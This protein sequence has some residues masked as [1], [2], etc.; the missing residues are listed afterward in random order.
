MTAAPSI[1]CIHGV[2]HGDADRA[3]R[4][5]WRRAI[6]AGIERSNAQPAP[7]IDF[8]DYDDLFDHA[9]LDPIVYAQALEHLLESG[10]EHGLLGAREFAGLPDEIRWTAGMIAQWASEDALRAELRERLQSKMRDKPYDAVCAFSLGSLLS[11]DTFSRLPRAIAGKDY[12]TLGSQ[13][14]D[15]YVRDFFP[16]S[17]AVPEGARTWYHLYNPRDRV[18]TSPLRIQ[19]RNFM[20]V[21]TEF[22][23]PDDL[24]NHDAIGYLDHPNARRDVWP[25]I[26][27]AAA[28]SAPS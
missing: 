13:I 27:R 20:Q 8:L 25:R 15:S 2:G 3:L 16:G 28:A 12:I 21:V 9:P 23:Q 11:Y 5:R 18:F 6:R 17:I 26:A 7:E 1:L 10:V 22:D 19:A 24:L 4:P 14:G